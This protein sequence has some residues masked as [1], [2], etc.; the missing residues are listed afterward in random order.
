MT[1]PSSSEKKK[2]IENHYLDRLRAAMLNFPAGRIEPTE[3]PDFL[4]HVDNHVIGI[5]LTEL[6][7]E[8]PG[9]VKPQQ[10]LEAMRHRV[11]A[12]AQELYIAA[13][14]PPV[15]V[16]IFMND[17][18]DIKK[19]QVLPL[20]EKI[21]KLVAS[22]LP[23]KNSSREIEYDWKTP[24]SFPAPLIQ[25]SVLR[26]DVI[27]KTF[28][29]APGATWVSTLT[30]ADIERAVEPKEK[31]YSTYRMKCDEA[32]LLINA[33]I[34]SMSTWFEFESSALSKPLRTQFQRVFVLR[35]F[36]GHLFELPIVRV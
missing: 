5:E 32:W 9:G 27:T 4:V 15:N 31:K 20:A 33:D 13:K 12:K 34:R 14:L 26:L 11:V 17:G 16:S 10:A 30:D 7:R 1:S 21:H 36:G 25:I 18:Y 8:T 2:E 24:G 22:Q 19:E 29:S 6:H 28:F 23:D 35:H 3:E